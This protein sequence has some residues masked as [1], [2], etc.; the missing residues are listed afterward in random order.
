MQQWQRVEPDRVVGTEGADRVIGI[1][2]RQPGER[3]NTGLL[4]QTRHRIPK[5]PNG[6]IPRS[7]S[8]LNFGLVSAAPGP[9]RRG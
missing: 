9:G 5:A 8:I 7:T 3:A 6:F 1:V 2:V 4:R